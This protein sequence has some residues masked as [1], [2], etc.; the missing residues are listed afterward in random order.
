MPRSISIDISAAVNQGAGIGRYARELTRRLVPLLPPESTRLWYAADRTPFDPDLV[1][2]EPWSSIPVTRS[3][4]SRL[5]V[6]RLHVRG[7]FGIGTLMRLG[8]FSD[9]YSPDFTAPE[10]GGVRTHVTV[11]D[12]AWLR[13]EAACPPPLAAFLGPAVEKAVAR[14]S[15]VFTVSEAIRT[16]VLERYLLPDERVIC[17]PNAA[18][19]RFFS[20][21]PLDATTL[22]TFGIT[23]PFFVYVGTIEP[24][25][26]VPLLF[27]AMARVAGEA[28]LLLIGRNGWRA[29]EILSQIDARGLAGRVIHAGFVPEDVLPGLIA[30]SNGLVYPSRYEGFG[31]PIVE[32]LAA[33]VPVAASD[34]PVFHEVGGDEVLYFDAEA[35]EDAASTLARM[36]ETGQTSDKARERRRARARTFDWYSSARVV[37]AR[38]L[39]EN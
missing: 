19:E 8:S 14:A 29:E 21:D 9:S 30:A 31:L 36:L 27:D 13:P 33:G 35:P 3:R 34:L 26:N 7:G 22:V 39:A 25:K 16:E 32:G 18:D 28:Q 2:R 12:L 15:S 23:G 11:H 5:N 24:R 4:I 10:R 17:A 1:E 6:D 38:L 37:A 20:A